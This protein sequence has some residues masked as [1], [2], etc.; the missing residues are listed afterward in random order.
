MKTATLSEIQTHLDR[1]LRDCASNGPVIILA[2]GKPVGMLVGPPDKDDLE[3]MAVSQTPKFKAM[4]NR[5]YKSLREGKGIP[6]DEFWAKV[7]TRTAKSNK[8]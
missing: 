1:F 5:S 2:G 3:M 4:L 7:R 8:R 6:H